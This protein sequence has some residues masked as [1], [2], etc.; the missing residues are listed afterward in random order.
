MIKSEKY[1][2]HLIQFRKKYKYVSKD[3]PASPYIIGYVNSKE[4]SRGFTKGE[5][6]NNIKRRLNR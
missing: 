3:Y 5:V 4:F 2:G 1:K 6:F